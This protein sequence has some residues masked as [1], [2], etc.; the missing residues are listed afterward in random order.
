MVLPFPLFLLV[1]LPA[2]SG[3]MTHCDKEQATLKQDADCETQR[4]TQ[5]VW[6]GGSV[7]GFVSGVPPSAVTVSKTGWNV[8]TTY[9][10]PEKTTRYVHTVN[11]DPAVANI[12]TVLLW[13]IP[14]TGRTAK[15]V[16]SIV[17]NLGGISLAQNIKQKKNKCEGKKAAWY[18]TN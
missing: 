11:S 10:G 15:T 16:V 8:T 6:D 4:D 12:N 17:I 13:Y 3:R 5:Q 18:S 7:H 1:P 2:W 9:R 14:N